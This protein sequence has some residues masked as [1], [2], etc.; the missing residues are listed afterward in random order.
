MVAVLPT[1]WVCLPHGCAHSGAL[2]VLAMVGSRALTYKEGEG[3][4][5]GG[6]GGVRS[7]PPTPTRTRTRHLLPV[8]DLYF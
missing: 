8:H 2:V 5:V 3:S 4:V 7:R 6:E 1:R